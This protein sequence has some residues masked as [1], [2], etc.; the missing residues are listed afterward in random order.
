MSLAERTRDAV[1]Q[2]PF[3]HEAL[4]TGVLNYR[5]AAR[6]LDIDGDEDAIAT[7]L[8][9]YADTLSE[10]IQQST[11]V[12]RVKRGVG[13]ADSSEPSS[14]PLLQIGETTVIDQGDQ[15]AVLISGSCSTMDQ[16]RVLTRLGI[17][18]IETY[19]CG[20]SSET[21]II[22]VSNADGMR[23]LRLIEQSFQNRPTV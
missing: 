20:F 17:A 21:G 23:A 16:A 19:A 6:T 10:P 12:V 9:R 11:P 1:Q 18:D 14:S 4:R 15:T 22:V 5:A 7:A 2:T 8:R 13:I 3:L